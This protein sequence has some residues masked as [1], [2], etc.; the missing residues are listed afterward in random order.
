MAIVTASYYK[1]T[2]RAQHTCS[3]LC[4]DDD[5]L[6]EYFNM[7]RYYETRKRMLEA[8]PE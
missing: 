2:K 4:D 1:V 5:W 8:K 6:N 7:L 3:T